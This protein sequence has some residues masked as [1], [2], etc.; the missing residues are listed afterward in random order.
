MTALASAAHRPGRVS[1]AAQSLTER[2]CLCNA[3]QRQLHS[4]TCLSLGPFL[5]WFAWWPGL[6][7]VKIMPGFQRQIRHSAGQ[8]HTPGSRRCGLEGPLHQPRQGSMVSLAGMLTHGGICPA[9]ICMCTQQCLS[10][11]GSACPPLWPGALPVCRCVYLELYIL[12]AAGSLL[13]AA[14]LAAVAALS[15]LKLPQAVVNNSGNVML[16]EA[17]QQQEHPKQTPAV[18]LRLRAVPLCT[19]CILY[20]GQLLTDPTAEEEA[21]AACTISTAMDERDRLIAGRLLLAARSLMC[22]FSTHLQLLR[23]GQSCPVLLCCCCL[24]GPR[25]PA[26]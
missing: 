23:Q 8:Q 26:S 16:R 12:D 2:V 24:L 3:L 7:A 4:Q 14:L 18:P 20:E 9:C 1:S 17:G 5:P 10:P 19:T 13:D 15:T 25:S 21:L 6:R 22:W 11:T